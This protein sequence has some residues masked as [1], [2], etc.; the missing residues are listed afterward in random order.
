MRGFAVQ[1]GSWLVTMCLVCIGW[2]LFRS[3]TFGDAVTVL[4]N[5]MAT[6]GYSANQFSTLFAYTAPLAI[7]EI[8]Q[9]ASGRLE[10]LTAGPF[11]VR[12]TAAVALVLTLIAFSAPGGQEFI[13]FDF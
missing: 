12:Y 8:Y 6:T 9:R 7:V 3:R 4:Q 11:L 1:T 10:V 2:I 5:L 13:Y